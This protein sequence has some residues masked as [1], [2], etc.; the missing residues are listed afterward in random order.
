MSRVGKY[1]VALKNGATAEVKGQVVTVK[2]KNGTMTYNVRPNVEVKL[3]E[4][5]LVVSPR[6]NSKK[7]RSQ[8]GTDR[9][10]LN[11]LVTGVTTGFTKTLEIEGVGFKAAVQGS[12][13]VLSLGFS[14]E[15]RFTI[16]AGI[17]VKADKPTVLTITGNDRQVVG[18]VAAVIRGYKKPE[19][20]KGKGIRY[21]GERILR[22]E[23]KKK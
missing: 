10:N 5:G 19:P 14:H 12:D 1:P 16:P 4:A 9:A 3:E 23:G 20:Y 15:V 6:S 21:A 11:N 22:K 7:D 17:T 13:V 18:Q 8:W 2:G